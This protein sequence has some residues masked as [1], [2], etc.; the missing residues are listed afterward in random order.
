MFTQL[1]DLLYVFV[2]NSNQNMVSFTWLAKHP[3]RPQPS[4]GNTTVSAPSQARLR[5]WRYCECSIWSYSS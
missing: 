4:A 5:K 3:M 1:L 2:E